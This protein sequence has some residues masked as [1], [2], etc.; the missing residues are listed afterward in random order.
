VAAA[1]LMVA[2]AGGKMTDLSGQTVVLDPAGLDCLASNN[3]LH[4]LLTG[5]V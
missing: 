4:E 5:Q 3:H 2:L 1:G